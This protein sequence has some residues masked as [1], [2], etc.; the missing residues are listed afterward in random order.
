MRIASAGLELQFCY[1]VFSYVLTTG[2]FT[3]KLTCPQNILL[4]FHLRR[5]VMVFAGYESKIGAN[6]GTPLVSRP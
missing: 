3:K 6:I 1:Q 4:A 5:R 2:E